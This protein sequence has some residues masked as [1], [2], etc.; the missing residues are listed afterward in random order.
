MRTVLN[1]KRHR[2]KEGEV[3]VSGGGR[4]GGGY[5]HHLR[6]GTWMFEVGESDRG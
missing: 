5:K 3:G 6:P 4:G 2:V 1:G